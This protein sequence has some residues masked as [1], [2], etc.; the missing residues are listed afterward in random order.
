MN[1]KTSELKLELFQLLNMIKDMEAGM[2][3]EIHDAIYLRYK[4]K[5][6]A[7]HFVELEDAQVTDKDRK[8]YINCDDNYIKNI[9]NIKSMKYFID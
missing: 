7:I 4:D 2:D 8:N 5:P 1:K 3:G 9:K 6:Y